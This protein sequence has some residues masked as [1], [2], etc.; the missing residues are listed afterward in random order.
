[1]RIS[2]NGYTSFEKKKRALNI[3]KEINL[4]K[5][6]G[7]KTHSKISAVV[8][9]IKKNSLNGKNKIVFCH[10]R[11][12]ID[13]LKELLSDITFIHLMDALVKRNA[14][15]SKDDTADVLL[16]QIQTG[17]EGLNLQQYSEVYLQALIEP[18]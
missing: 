4:A 8:D 15:I 5:L 14:T 16:I 9:K 13:K 10:Y 18:C 12:E 7:V 17:C 3:G 11:A 2:S 1:M 6:N